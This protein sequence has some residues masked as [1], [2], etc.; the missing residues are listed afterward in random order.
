MSRIS[1]RH[2]SLMISTLGSG[3]SCF[4]RSRYPGAETGNKDLWDKAFRH[5]RILGL[6]VLLRMCL[7]PCFK[8]THTRF[9]S[10]SSCSWIRVARTLG[11]RLGFGSSGLGSSAGRGHCVVFLGKPLSTPSHPMQ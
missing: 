6:S 3:Q 10:Q 8:G 4:Q 9:L 7:T 2:S 5:D 1:G 11:T